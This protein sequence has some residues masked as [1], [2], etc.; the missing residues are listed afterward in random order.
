MGEFAAALSR[1]MP[2]PVDWT[3][4]NPPFRLA[5]RMAARAL[6]SSRRGV[7]IFARTAFLEGI[8]RWQRLF[9]VMPPSEVLQFA[10]RVPIHKGRLVRG[11]STATA[12]CWIVWVRKQGRLSSP[13][14]GPTEF[15]WI[16]PCRKRLEKEDDY[17]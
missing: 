3:I 9:S 11:G 13:L 17:D 7:A 15:R 1:P 16:P 8:G 6:E 10:E 12:Y 14:R 4:T 5:E 2:P